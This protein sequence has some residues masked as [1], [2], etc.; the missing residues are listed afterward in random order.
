MSWIEEVV[1]LLPDHRGRNHEYRGAFLPEPL[2]TDVGEF[3]G[4]RVGGPVARQI[5]NPDDGS[6]QT[7]GNVGSDSNQIITEIMELDV[8]ECLQ[9]RE[10]KR[11]R[12]VDGGRAAR[13]PSATVDS[14]PFAVEGGVDTS[15]KPP[16]AG[17]L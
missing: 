16:D 6:S 9:R 13:I 1:Q 10:G 7:I 17:Q 3:G 14:R 15:R 8:N 11:R 4:R 2:S 5:S 12:S